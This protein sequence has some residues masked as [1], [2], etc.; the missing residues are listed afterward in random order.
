M[1]CNIFWLYRK[2]PLH[3]IVKGSACSLIQ[4]RKYHQN[5]TDKSFWVFFQFWAM[6]QKPVSV[7]LWQLYSHVLWP[8]PFIL[9]KWYR[10]FSSGWH[11]LSSHPRIL[12]L[13]CK[14]LLMLSFGHLCAIVL[15]T[16]AADFETSKSENLESGVIR[17]IWTVIHFL[18][19]R[20]SSPHG[21]VLTLCGTSL[22]PH[23]QE[24]ISDV[25]VVYHWSFCFYAHTT[26]LGLV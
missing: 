5:L 10:N 26:L 24:F 17:L 15:C 4:N 23:T 8:S 13:L 21:V 1:Y 19:S 3:P 12:R 14:L 18:F 6:S 16:S 9:S 20:L 25:S 22:G 11:C 2:S 7:A